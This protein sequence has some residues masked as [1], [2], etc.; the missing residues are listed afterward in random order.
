MCDVIFC[1]PFFFGVPKR[2]KLRVGHNRFVGVSFF[3]VPFGRGY[4]DRLVA[5]PPA[6][7]KKNPHEVPVRT[8]SPAFSCCFVDGLSYSWSDLCSI[9]GPFDHLRTHTPF[10]YRTIR[11][12]SSFSGSLHTLPSLRT[13]TL[14]SRRDVHPALR[15]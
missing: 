14:E 4:G 5:L 13:Q 7:V 2:M 15:K 12:L 9:R 1:F 3:L 10:S 6:D 8:D 11:F